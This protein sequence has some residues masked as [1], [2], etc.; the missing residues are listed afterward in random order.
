VGALLVQ[1]SEGRDELYQPALR[2]DL[3]GPFAMA[4]LLLRRGV[5]VLRIRRQFRRGGF[6]HLHV[7]YGYFAAMAPGLRFSL[8]LHGGDLLMDLHGGLKTRLTLSA[9]ARASHVVVSTPNLLPLARRYRADSVY[10]PNPMAIPGWKPRHVPRAAPHIILLSKMD[11]LKGWPVQIGVI[12]ALRTRLPGLTFSFCRDGQLAEADRDAMTRE[13]VALGGSPR[14]FMSRDAF[15][16]LVTS[17]DFALGQLELGALGMSELEAMAAGLPTIADATAH[18]DLGY[19]PA[20]IPPAQAVDTV[21]DLWNGGR[22]ARDAFGEQGREYVVE[23]HRPLTS[24][25]VLETFLA[26]SRVVPS[27]PVPQ[28]R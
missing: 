21:V 4:S 26:G 24:L 5:D 20:V 27:S 23:V 10:I 17:S 13:L 18:F 28:P 7:H 16:A 11:P 22:G 2:R 1:A 3:S 19:H 8:H 12:R 25:Q 14:S 9:I 6:T 15:V